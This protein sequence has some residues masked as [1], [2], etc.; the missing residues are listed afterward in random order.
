MSCRHHCASDSPRWFLSSARRKREF[1]DNHRGNEPRLAD[2]FFYAWFFLD[3]FR[4]CCAGS[5]VWSIS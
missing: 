2:W 4:F 5:P 1:C 3:C